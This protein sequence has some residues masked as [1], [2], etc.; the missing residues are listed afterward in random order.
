M[1][2][3]REHIWER[4]VRGW[5]PHQLPPTYVYPRDVQQGQVLD[6]RGV[7]VS[8]G[9]S[10][11]WERD[12]F[13]IHKPTGAGIDEVK[14]LLEFK[15]D[16][17]E[18]VLAF[19]SP[20][21]GTFGKETQGDT[22]S[23]IDDRITGSWFACSAATCY[24]DKLTAYLRVVLTG[25]TPTVKAAVYR[26]SDLQLIAE[27]DPVEVTST[28]WTDF[29]FPEWPALT[30]T[31]YVLVVWA[32]D[33]AGSS[34]YVSATAAAAGSGPYD[35]ETFGDWPD[36]MASTYESRQYSIYATYLTLAGTMHYL[37]VD[38]S[39]ET[40][41]KGTYGYDLFGDLSWSQ[42]SG[43]TVPW[44]GPSDAV[45]VREALLMAFGRG[46]PMVRWNGSTLSEVGIA[47]PTATPTAA[48]DTTADDPGGTG[49]PAGTYTYVFTYYDGEFE[50][51]PSA[52]PS[53][54]TRPVSGST[55]LPRYYHSAGVSAVIADGDGV[56]VANLADHAS[57]YQKRIYR[58]YTP[59]T[60]PGAQGAEFYYIATVA[61][62]VTTYDDDDVPPYAVGTAPAFDHARPPAAKY[63]CWHKERVWLAG[64]SEGS[65]DYA[66]Y[67]T[68]YWLN[69][70]FWSEI[71]EPYYYP[72]ANTLR[73]G[74]D[75]PITGLAS[76]GDSL[77]VFKAN[78]VWQVRGWSNNDIRVDLI[79]S[80]VGALAN[81]S[82]CAA[83][84]GVLWQASDGYYLWDGAEI[85]R[86]V[87]VRTDGPWQLTDPDI[88]AP[89]IAY[90]AGRFYIAQTGGWMEWEPSRDCWCYHEADLTDDDGETAGFRTY[91]W[92]AYQSHVLTRM[93]WTSGGD[94][95]I[96]VLDAGNAFD[97]GSTAGTTYS[98]L[99]A[100]VQITLA[101]LEAP[102][103]HQIVPMEV[104][105][106][107][108][109]TDDATANRRPKLFLNAD[110]SYSD[111]TGDN[112]WET[113]P[114]A[115]TE[116]EVVGVPAS[117]VYSSTSYR[118]NAAR[119]WYLQ[120]EGESG[121]DFELRA[122]RLIYRLV[123][124]RGA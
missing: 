29:D 71:D 81:S 20:D 33:L 118:T 79:T 97:N 87:E 47:V 18:Q 73:V 11:R 16:T 24:L 57:N 101:P 112:A 62:G 1:A 34:V 72:G 42:A 15:T 110:A 13:R 84:P 106:D 74:D 60:S 31:D 70:L 46:R 103:G 32:E 109:Y 66:N 83:P 78:S 80:Q 104:W 92:G 105:A 89:T 26:Y 69:V 43:A 6:A 38:W 3:V 96:T 115:P 8:R 35:A 113:T 94:Q 116:G 61:D 114:D 117:Y 85:R 75:T 53:G 51:M 86:V 40:P 45:Q 55:G 19:M 48:A 50:S 64:A 90:H 56:N 10:L 58:A 100:P 36:Y 107:C 124:E 77:V 108:E 23:E 27:S 21:K 67:S 30:N 122:V 119:R 22:E 9:G 121:A 65:Q 123:R 76:W 5:D 37:N 39:L 68:G 14:A 88:E 12:Q 54:V 25:G 98:A 28:G 111:T 93:P 41:A 17:Y 91:A 49:Y 63:A 95:E 4:F 52:V 7:R 102:P 99:R 59:D 2:E 44:W 82:Q 120:I